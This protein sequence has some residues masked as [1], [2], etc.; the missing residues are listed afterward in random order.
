MGSTKKK[1]G[2]IIV[3]PDV[4]VWPHEWDTARALASAGYVVEFI[5][6]SEEKFHTSADIMIDGVAWEIK[7]PK[8]KYM[9][10]VQENLR[11]ALHQSR[12]VIFDCRRMKNIP[13]TAVKRELIKWANELKELKGLKCV[14][15]HGIV[16]DIK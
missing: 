9:R 14:D 6:K 13:D 12:Y 1:Q 7:A 2:H 16:I 10:K 4:N 8:S 5:R 11:R 3:A 15:R